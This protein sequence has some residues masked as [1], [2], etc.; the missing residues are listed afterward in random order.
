MIIMILKIYIAI[1][2][3]ESRLEMELLCYG[4]FC[5]TYCDFGN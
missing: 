4:V 3:K 5:G 1:L 2:S